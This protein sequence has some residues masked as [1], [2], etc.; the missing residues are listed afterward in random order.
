MHNI[1]PTN[2]KNHKESQGMPLLNRMITIACYSL[3]ESLA[4]VNVLVD[5]FGLVGRRLGWSICPQG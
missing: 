4:V 5:D 1:H 3:E 2:L